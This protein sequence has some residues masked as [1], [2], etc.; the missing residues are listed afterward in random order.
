MPVFAFPLQIS[1]IVSMLYSICALEPSI[2]TL[3]VVVGM[4]FAPSIGSRAAIRL[5]GVLFVD[6]WIWEFV[7]A[8]FILPHFLHVMLNDPSPQQLTTL[9]E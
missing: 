7:K 5:I 3:V 8:T 6:V 4:T 2:G 9:D 1:I